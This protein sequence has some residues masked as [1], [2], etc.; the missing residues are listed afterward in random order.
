MRVIA[1]TSFLMIP[2]M[3]GVDIFSELDRL[4]E[5][6]YILV[7]PKP[8][9][10]ELVE[11]SKRGKPKERAAAKVALKLVKHCSV[12]EETGEADE[13]ILRMAA[14][15]TSLVGTTDSV[16][17]RNLRKIRTP[18]IFIRKKSHLALDGYIG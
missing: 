2:G 8:V 11:I 16:L 15:K 6:L 5:R 1:D 12:V 7:V 9:L 4:L 10:L 14:K 13:A 18:V 3:F 17:R